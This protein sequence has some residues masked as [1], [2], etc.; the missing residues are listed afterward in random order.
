MKTLDLTIELSNIALESAGR[1]FTEDE[2][3]S[4]VQDILQLHSSFLGRP[5]GCQKQQK[6][7]GNDLSLNEYRFDYEQ[8]SVEVQFA[9]FLPRGEWQV[10]GIRLV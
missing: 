6:S 5:T 3:L 10:H 9:N 4:R 2:M 7:L 8:Y 1:C